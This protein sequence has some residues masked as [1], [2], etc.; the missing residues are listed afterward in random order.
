MKMCTKQ[1]HAAPPK[2]DETFCQLANV[3]KQLSPEYLNRRDGG[4]QVVCWVLGCL[5]RWVVPHCG[6]P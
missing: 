3:I 4:V 2:P 6:R 5:V 1:Q